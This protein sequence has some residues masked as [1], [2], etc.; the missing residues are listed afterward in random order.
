MFFV[1][2]LSFIIA[3]EILR[4]EIF[5]YPSAF[6]NT[7][8]SDVTVEG[9]IFLNG[10]YFKTVLYD[11]I[12]LRTVQVQHMY[13]ITYELCFTSLLT[14]V[15]KTLLTLSCLEREPLRAEH[16]LFFPVILKGS[17]SRYAKFRPSRR[18]GLDITFS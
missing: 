17:L 3:I 16:S 8:Y 5:E 9:F 13:S 4:S 18:H 10:R 1:F 2:F 12:F 7:E 15:Q 14:G 6:K 11:A